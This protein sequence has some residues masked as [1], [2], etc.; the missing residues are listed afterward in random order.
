MKNARVNKIRLRWFLIA[1]ALGSLYGSTGCGGAPLDENAAKERA[2]ALLQPFKEQMQGALK[3]GLAKGPDEAIDSCSVKAPQIAA[4]HS[5]DGVKVGR[6]SSKL[7]NPANNAPT[8]VHPLLSE[9]EKKNAP[10]GEGRVLQ[11]PSGNVGY[12]EP[13]RVAPL[14]LTCHGENVAKPISDKLA[15][16]YPQDKATGYKDGDFRGVFWVEMPKK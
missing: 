16:K 11:L 4:D 2:K 1:I 9:L 14:C 15:Q 10:A 12:V 13:I 5:K 6:A 3:E 8:W 7:R